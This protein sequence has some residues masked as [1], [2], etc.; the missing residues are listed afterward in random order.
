MRG[1]DFAPQ[2]CLDRSRDGLDL[3]FPRITDISA[4]QLLDPS[5]TSGLGGQV[6]TSA[7]RQLAAVEVWREEA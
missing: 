6:R 3:R 4:D 2:F 1:G 5:R 7:A